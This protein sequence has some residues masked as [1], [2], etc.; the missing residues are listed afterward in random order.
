MRVDTHVNGSRTVLLLMAAAVS[1][2]AACGDDD[3]S[4]TATTARRRAF[5]LTTGEPTV[6]GS[7]ADGPDTTTHPRRSATSSRGS[8]IRLGTPTDEPE[9]VA[10]VHPDGSDDHEILAE[11]P[12]PALNPDWSPDGTRLAVQIYSLDSVWIA[13]A[14]GS[15]SEAVRECTASVRSPHRP[16]LVSVR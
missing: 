13:N 16:R 11:L 5:R 6:T 2:L 4:E 1:T 15:A 8:P 12:D 10:L 9:G 7:T 14:D 3:A